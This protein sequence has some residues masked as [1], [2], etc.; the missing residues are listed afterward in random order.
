[1]TTPISDLVARLRSTH[2]FGPEDFEMLYE[3][4]DALEELQRDAERYRWLREQHWNDADMFVVTGSNTRVH[5]GTYCP[6]LDLL[7]IAIDAAL[8]SSQEKP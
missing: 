1:M 3:A 8:Q 2:R 6:S 5:L 7:D 4:A